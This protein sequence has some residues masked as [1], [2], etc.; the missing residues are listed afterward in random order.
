MQLL[1]RCGRRARVRGVVALRA[2]PELQTQHVCRCRRRPRQR[3]DM[4]GAGGAQR[5]MRAR[6]GTGSVWRWRTACATTT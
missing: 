1:G 5:A 6:A 4:P 3:P 2:I